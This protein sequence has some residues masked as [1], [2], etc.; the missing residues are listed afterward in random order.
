M[1]SVEAV[2]TL[3]VIVCEFPAAMEPLVDE[4][5]NQ[6]GGEEIDQLSVPVPVFWTTY[7]PAAGDGTANGPPCGPDA[8]TVDA[9]VKPSDGVP[10]KTSPVMEAPEME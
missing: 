10:V 4:K 6:V 8:L 1:A 5:L 3:T 9:G 7:C 2:F